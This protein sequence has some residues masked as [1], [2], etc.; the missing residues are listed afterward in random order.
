[1]FKEDRPPESL[2][3]SNRERLLNRQLLVMMVGV[4]G[5]GK[6]TFAAPLAEMIGAYRLNMDLLRGE[7]YGTTDRQDQINYDKR[8]RLGLNREEVQAFREQKRQ[9]ELEAFHEKLTNNLRVGRSVVVDS[10]CDSRRKRDKL[11]RAAYQ[12]GALPI[13]TW[14]QTAY[15][16]AIERATFRDLGPD[17]YPFEE[18]YLA[19]EEIDRCLRSLDLPAEDEFCVPIDGEQGF[20]GQLE[21]LLATLDDKLGSP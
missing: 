5:S 10:S 20:S 13:V 11:R 2:S 8:A 1:M 15:P 6:T 21:S 17:S 18:E 12:F 4:P 9:R 14:M 19:R 7:I 16:R 3:S